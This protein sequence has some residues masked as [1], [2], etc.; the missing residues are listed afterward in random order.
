MN[1]LDHSK[2][3]KKQKEKEKREESHDWEHEY[4]RSWI[5]NGE[6]TTRKIEQYDKTEKEQ[7]LREIK[8][9]NNYISASSTSASSISA[10]SV[11][12]AGKTDGI[13]ID[14]S[15][16]GHEGVQINITNLITSFIRKMTPEEAQ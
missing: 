13:L 6:E 14:L 15:E 16:R 5:A 1:T 10:S 12:T 4:S 8:K 9:L 7:L 3:I 2:K 11:H